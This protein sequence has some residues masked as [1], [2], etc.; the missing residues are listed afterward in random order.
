M[1]FAVHPGYNTVDDVDDDLR[2]LH[3]RGARA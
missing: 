3:G 2:Q 1:N